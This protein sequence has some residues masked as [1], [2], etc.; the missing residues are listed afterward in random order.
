MCELSLFAIWTQKS[1]LPSYAFYF[2]KGR[3]NQ[4]EIRINDIS[5]SRI[6]C[7]INIHGNDLYVKDMDSKYG[8]L[9]FCHRNKLKLLPKKTLSIQIANTIFSFKYLLPFYM[10]LCTC[11]R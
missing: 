11:L 10:S 4:A 9:V 2:N 8:I 3:A 1:K 6:H 7:V 5:V